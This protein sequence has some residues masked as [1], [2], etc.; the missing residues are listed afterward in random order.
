MFFH[1]SLGDR[2]V[3]IVW[4]ETQQNNVTETDI[5][6]LYLASG[7]DITGIVKSVLSSD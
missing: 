2:L 1:F 5:K 6:K 3:A 4:N 7:F